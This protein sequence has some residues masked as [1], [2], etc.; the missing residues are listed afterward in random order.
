[1][2]ALLDV[3]THLRQDDMA[4]RGET[5]AGMALAGH[6][7]RPEDPTALKASVLV[8]VAEYFTYVRVFARSGQEHP[9]LA[10]ATSPQDIEAIWALGRAAV[11][12]AVATRA[13]EEESVARMRQLLD[14]TALPE[15][16]ICASAGMEEREERGQ[17]GGGQESQGEGQG[18][19][20]WWKQRQGAGQAAAGNA[21]VAVVRAPPPIFP[22]VGPGPP[23][24]PR[25]QGRDAVVT[26]VTGGAWVRGALVLGCSLPP[27]SERSYDLVAICMEMGEEDRRAM[28]DAG[29]TCV[30][31]PL[32]QNPWRT[33]PWKWDYMAKIQPY[34]MVQYRRILQLD[35]DILVT[36]S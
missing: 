13:D 8:R 6:W 34:S 19:G 5:L 18:W 15:D 25:A 10:N 26:L 23:P 36:V 4:Q 1:M 20:S 28:A 27:A 30:S 17:E 16:Q 32:I 21:D 24:L 22:A 33:S 14:T 2:A 9:V 11:S 3:A 12:R 35:S 7:A 31:P 29:W